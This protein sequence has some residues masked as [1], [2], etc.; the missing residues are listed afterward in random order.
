LLGSLLF[1]FEIICFFGIKIKLTCIAFLIVVIS[2]N[3]FILF[4]FFDLYGRYLISGPP[5]QMLIK[6]FHISWDTHVQLSK[7]FEFIII[8]FSDF[9]FKQESSCNIKC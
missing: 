7:Y 6:K 1:L 9:N 2:L 4:L 5:P 8:R 3:S